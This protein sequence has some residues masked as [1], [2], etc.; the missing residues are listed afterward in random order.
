MIEKISGITI[1]HHPNSEIRSYL[2]SDEISRYR[3]ERF[4]SDDE[5]AFETKLKALGAIGAHVIQEVMAISGVHD[6]SIKPR[7]LRVK[8]ETAAAWDPI[9]EK[10][11]N[12]LNTAFRRKTIH[13]V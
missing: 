13:L 10:I 6:V 12:A 8:K 1:Y 2:T 3:V 4:R 9:Q 11:I 7:E 5:E